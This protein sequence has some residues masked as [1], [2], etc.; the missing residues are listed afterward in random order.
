MKY[1]I[2]TFGCQMNQ[3]DSE[4]IARILEQAGYQPA[5]SIQSANLV[6]IN[7]CS[8]RQSAV[9]RVYGLFKKLTLK[10]QKNP[11][12]KIL[13]TGC[14]LPIDRKKMAE[15][16]D[17][18]FDIKDL[19]NLPRILQKSGILRLSQLL[20]A[21]SK[22]KKTGINYF[23][24]RPLY[25]SPFS[26]YVPIMTGCNN[27]CS[28]CVVPYARGREISRP[29]DKILDEVKKLIKRGYKKIVL[30][31]QNVNSYRSPT[32]YE[33]NTNIQITNVNFPKLLQLINKIP[34]KFWL[35]FITSHP[36]DLS[37]E[38]INTMAEC[39]K[40]TP[41]LHL[42]VQSGDNIILKKMNRH[43]TVEHY[44]NL[45]RVIRGKFV[46]ISEPISISTDIIVG[47]PGETKKQ[48]LNTAKLMRKIKFDMAYIAEYSPREGTAAAKL[49]DNVDKKEKGRRRVALTEILKKTA[50]E[51]NKKYLGQIVDVLIT[52]H[53]RKEYLIGE[54]RTFK[55]VRICT[56]NNNSHGPIRIPRLR[57][58]SEEVGL[59]ACVKITE[60]TPWGLTGKIIE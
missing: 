32:N 35:Q 7:M 41:Y 39:E 58:G 25:A 26:A 43:Y 30:L 48:F 16:V 36:K 38:L 28:Y 53:D 49:K 15:R 24:I 17:L 57:P 31:G 40:I 10:K 51:N 52:G 6:V 29:A 20:S 9:D 37:D 21:S 18:I 13:L 19:I 23:S 5:G 12:F 42:P 47:F 8:V 45:I 27:F 33:S 14:I 34:G 59:F 1:H 55:N 2:V 4:R 50:L 3:S 54:T 60:V 11:N 44:K 56:L 46:K 22:I